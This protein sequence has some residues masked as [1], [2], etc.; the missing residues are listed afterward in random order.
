MQATRLAQ[1]SAALSEA[2]GEIGNEG[3]PARISKLAE[4][5]GGYESTVIAAFRTG[6]R[7]TR[8]F[9]DLSDNDCA[10]TIEPYFTK[11]YLLDIWYNMVLSHVPD[12][13]YRVMD[14][15]PDDFFN[16]TY[17]HTYYKRTR[18]VDECGVFV[19][20]TD[21]ICVVLMLGN[22]ADE[23]VQNNGWLSEIADLLPVFS[24]M[25]RI[26]WRDLAALTVAPA[27]SLLNMCKE[28]GLAKRESEVT[29]YLLQGHSNKVIARKLGIS[30]E[31]VKV[32][33]KRINKKL[34]TSSTSQVFAKFFPQL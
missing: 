16:S 31:T 14:C 11:A 2:I 25:I 27:E 5:A 22:R 19:W 3:F 18:L 28:H 33:R 26:H 20:L 23:G 4:M 15:A 12:G 32:Y 29:A 7:P 1:L 34:G 6:G 21:E 10:T 30:P 13:V 17:Y 24:R 9:S 8:L